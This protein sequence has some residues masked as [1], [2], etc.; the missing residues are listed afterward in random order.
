MR[1]NTRTDRYP[2]VEHRLV[3]QPAGIS[4]IREIWCDLL[5]TSVRCIINAIVFI[6]L[7]GRGHCDQSAAH[8]FVGGV[9]PHVI[10]RQR[11]YS[12]EGRLIACGPIRMTS[13]K[14]RAVAVPRADTAAISTR[15]HT[16]QSRKGDWEA[17]FSK[18][19][20]QFGSPELGLWAEC[21]Q[22]LMI[23]GVDLLRASCAR[24]FV[25]GHSDSPSRHCRKSMEIVVV[26]ICR[27]AFVKPV[28]FLS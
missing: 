15:S 7:R 14:C 9:K 5:R 28:V 6:P 21:L 22:T 24:R 12:N 26:L 25:G 13:P 8:F 16:R 23:R 4:L 2:P 27:G 20:S 17:A 10:R 3:I 1:R 11:M 19:G 18:G